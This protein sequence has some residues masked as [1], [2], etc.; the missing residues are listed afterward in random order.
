MGAGGGR[1][2]EAAAVVFKRGV[3]SGLGKGAP[4]R[5]RPREACPNRTRRRW[6]VGFPRGKATAARA[7]PG[8]AGPSAQSGARY[9]F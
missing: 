7:W 6:R 2:G 1:L 8:S 4:G 5:G 9:F 3:A